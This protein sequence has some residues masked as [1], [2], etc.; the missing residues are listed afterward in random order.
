MN[1]INHEHEKNVQS[2]FYRYIQLTYFNANP[3][4][5]F[6]RFT[7]GNRETLDKPGWIEALKEFHNKW[8]SANVMHL[9]VYSNKQLDELEIEVADLF[10]EIE[11]K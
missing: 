3:K 7:T 9:V 10:S 2:D 1:A 4:S 5:A 6:N 8:Y 11:N